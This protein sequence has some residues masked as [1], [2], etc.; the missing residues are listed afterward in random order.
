[1]GL[2]VNSRSAPP[3]SHTLLSDL[4]D[5]SSDHDAAEG[6]GAA[7]S[8]GTAGAGK[9]HGPGSTKV[10]NFIIYIAH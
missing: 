10:H 4:S 6:P 8:A 3:N 1:M 5:L 9:V 2:S 7:G